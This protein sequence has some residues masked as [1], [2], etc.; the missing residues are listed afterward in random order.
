MIDNGWQVSTLRR[1][2]DAQGRVTHVSVHVQFEERWTLPGSSVT[3]R[4][5]GDNVS[6]AVL[7]TPGDIPSITRTYRG[8]IHRVVGPD[9]VLVRN[10]GM[11]QDNWDESEILAMHG[12]FDEFTDFEA[13]VG[14]VCDA[15][16]A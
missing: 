6:T 14:R 2:H 3:L 13:A 4:S 11:L 1:E 12:T 7:A 15:F 16:G 9:G 10:T 8:E 5:W